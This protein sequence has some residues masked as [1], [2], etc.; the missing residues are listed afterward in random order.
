MIRGK[1][2]YA[3]LLVIAVFFFILYRGKLSFELLIFAFLFPIP[4]WLST[5]LLK[6]SLRMRVLHSREPIL[7][8][9]TWQWVLEIENSSI[10]SS[11]DA[12][13]KLEYFNSLTGKRQPLT[14]VVPVLARN[15]Q[16]VRFAFHSVTCG[17]MQISIRELTVFD[18][19]RIF[20]RKIPL[21][22]KDTVVIMPTP[23]ALLPQEFPQVP[24]PDADT[25]E[26]SKIKAGDD[27]SEIFDLHV[28]REGDAVSRI[29]WKLS[30]KLDTLLV[31]EYS[32]PLAAGCLLMPDYRNTGSQPE[33]AL[34]LDT[35]LSAMSAAAAQ[36]TEQ[37]ISF[38]FASCHPEMGIQESELFS[39]LPDA[40]HW[41]RHLVRFQP[42][43]TDRAESLHSA[44]LDF[45]NEKRKYERVF[46]FTPKLDALLTEML[47]SLPNPERIIVF[48]AVTAGDAVAS[49]PDAY[50]FEVIPVEQEMPVHTSMR[51][52]RAEDVPDFD[53]EVL[54][55][56]GAEP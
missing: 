25:S 30:S 40:V 55:E 49:E 4:L 51:P 48:A 5:F 37:G 56:G 21:A 28:Y 20:K 23:A 33:S 19:L 12:Q 18:P 1:L 8:G 2:L 53:S 42:V 14:L 43:T 44:M 7:K 39:A 24:Q 6:R 35:A 11:P 15:T 29:H 31:K 16:R 26:Y 34:R 13:V 38:A 46:L 54:V 50:P 45:I 52:V 22:L 41:L 36:L 10:F 17:V 9:K 32:L 47:L 3:C 27:P